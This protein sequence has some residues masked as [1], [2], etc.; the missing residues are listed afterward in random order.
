MNL[1]TSLSGHFWGAGGVSMFRIDDDL[2]EFIQSGVA[3]IVGTGDAAGRPAIAWGWAPR[4]ADDRTTLELYLDTARADTTLANLRDNGQIAVTMADP[5]SYRSVQ[6]KGRFIDACETSEE[7]KPWVQQ[8]REAFVT[9]TSLIGDP[10]G[11]IQK[12]WMD[13]TTRVAFK[14]ERAF[15]QTPGPEAGR[16]L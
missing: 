6:F 15:D 13:E 8:Q 9:T 11:I 7:D 1:I 4:V 10:P 14:V 3:T 2:K 5:V 12:M 16:P